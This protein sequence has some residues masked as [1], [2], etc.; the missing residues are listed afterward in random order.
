MPVEPADEHCK[1][2]N[3]KPIDMK[4][5]NNT[6]CPRL[7]ACHGVALT[8]ILFLSLS[9]VGCGSAEV[10]AQYS[11]TPQL[12]AIYPDYTHVTV[13]VNIAPL[14]MELTSPA[15]DV[16]TR[17]SYGND[18][19]VCAGRKAQ[20]DLNAWKSLAAA[21]KGNDIRVDVYAQVRGQWTHYKPFTI[22]VSPDSIDP[23]ISYRLIAPSYVTYEELT[24][25]QR[26][27]ENYEETVVYNNMLAAN[28]SDGQCI[29][30]HNVQNYNPDRYQF[31]ARQNHGGTFIEY[32]GKMQKVNMN[33]D[34]IL[35]S[36]V[37]PAWHPTLK[38]LAYSTDK[39]MQS[40]HTRDINKIEVLDQQSDLIL[41]DPD[42][43]EVSTILNDSTEFEVFP[44]WSPDGKYLYYSSAHF[45]YHDTV[46]HD[47]EAIARAK[48]I[49]YSLY[50][51]PFDAKTRTFGPRELV[52]DAAG[53]GKSA[54]FPRVSPDGR[55][56]LFS[57]GGWGCFHVWHR[58][59]DLWMTDLKTMKTYPLTAANSNSAESY[60][61]WSSNGRWI[62]FSSRR[63]DGVYT[64]PY[65]AHIDKKGRPSKAFE[66]PQEDPDFYHQFMKSYNA[67]IF[68]RG[69][70]KTKPQDIYDVLKKDD[71]TPVTYRS[72]SAH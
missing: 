15:E 67:T 4:L 20:P 26:C 13:P 28:D 45:E 56:L 6:Y 36:G 37:Y 60:H 19:I 35:S 61:E 59:A 52:F 71:V 65:I 46:P 48:E 43:N 40:F 22:T 32:D 49:K 24:I 3:H 17:Y 57:L 38:L 8:L 11:E 33:N 14:S 47:V 31:H 1:L 42:K 70:V 12:P 2:T 16:V 9:L 23:Y 7:R 18:E 44:C 50:R 72:S 30:C 54:T 63:D 58:D 39:T 25:N 27:L 69:P 10:P 29:N 21:A 41:F 55:F 64:R 62:V 68:M 66:L 51:L 53:M 5:K 34:S